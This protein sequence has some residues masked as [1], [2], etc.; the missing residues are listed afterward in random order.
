MNSPTSYKTNLALNSCGKHCEPKRC[1]IRDNIGTQGTE[2]PVG[3]RE[4][5]KNLLTNTLHLLSEKY[6]FV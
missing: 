1:S 4:R 3:A 2:K 6:R 5:I